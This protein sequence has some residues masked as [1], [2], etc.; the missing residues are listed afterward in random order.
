MNLR[1]LGDALDHWKGSLF[2][3]L[4]KTNQLHNFVVDPTAA[5]WGSWQPEHVDAF[6]R[7]LRIDRRQ[8]ILHNASLKD[9]TM[10]FNEI[11]SEGD[12]FLD[13]DTGIKTGRFRFSTTPKDS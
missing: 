9:R 13:P 11:R 1:F 2:E 8:I 6:A 10:Y 3:L 5:D 12:L 7:L 4:Q